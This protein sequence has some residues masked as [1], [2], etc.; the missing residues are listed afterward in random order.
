MSV[1]IFLNHLKRSFT[2]VTDPY[3]LNTRM[4][5]GTTLDGI[6]I[7]A[8]PGEAY[9]VDYAGATKLKFFEN[10]KKS[11]EEPLTFVAKGLFSDAESEYMFSICNGVCTL[12]YDNNIKYIGQYTLEKGIKLNNDVYT[13]P[14]AVTNTQI[15][16]TVDSVKRKERY[17]GKMPHGESYDRILVCL[18]QFGTMTT[19]EIANKIGVPENRISGRISEMCKCGL[20]RKNGSK[21]VDGR[22]QTLWV[23]LKKSKNQKGQ[24]RY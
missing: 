16:R 9:M 12:H 21:S 6:E 19:A 15:V 23:L 3:F 13:V 20:I 8:S 22:K 1:A 14:N 11:F 17:T 24:N 7:C 10:V 4:M 18:Q 5:C 2:L